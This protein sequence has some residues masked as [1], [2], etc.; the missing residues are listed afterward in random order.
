MIGV[1]V[2]RKLASL[3]ELQSIYDLEDLYN[4][5]EIIT[6]K[7]ANEQTSYKKAEERARTRR[8]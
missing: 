8:R 1:V 6:I 5:Y 4:L 3:Y 7:V 2:D